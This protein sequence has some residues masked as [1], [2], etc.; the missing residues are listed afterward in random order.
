MSIQFYEIM[1]NSPLR[2]YGK[3]I[4]LD[5]K[6]FE[7]QLYA[8]KLVGIKTKEDFEKLNVLNFDFFCED[9]YLSESDFHSD[10][11]ICG[12][13]DYENL[14]DDLKMDDIEH[15]CYTK[16]KILQILKNEEV[17]CWD[18]DRIIC[19]YWDGSNWDKIIICD[20]MWDDLADVDAWYNGSSCLAEDVQEELQKM[21]ELDYKRLKDG[22]VTTYIT[23]SGKKFIKADSRWQGDFRSI[24]NIYKEM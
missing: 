9:D 11:M 12:L 7:K 23:N 1:E 21:K 19:Q 6:D 8:D 15:S 22:L 20:Q 24:F 18:W 2:Q 13:F 5:T 4:K 14:L 3:Y 17:T 10:Y 16:E